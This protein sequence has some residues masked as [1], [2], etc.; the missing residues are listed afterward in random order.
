MFCKN[1][2]IRYSESDLTGRLSMEGLLRLFQDFG[3]EHALCRGLG[4]DKTMESRK[5]WYLLSWKIELLSPPKIGEEVS[6]STWFYELKGPMA[7]KNIIMTNADQDVLAK[8]DTMW[9]YVDVMTQTP[10]LP[11]ADMWPKEDM[12][13]E[14]SFE[15]DSR[16][17]PIIKP[18][19]EN[20]L[21]P[22]PAKDWVIDTNH[23]ANNTKLTLLAMA[24]SGADFG[25]VT[26]RA[27]FINQIPKGAMMYPFM[28]Q[29]KKQI[30]LAFKNEGGTD[31]ANFRFLLQ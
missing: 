29:T 9:V 8:A 20:A 25:C 5:T 22:L 14:L 15:K 6:L 19:G 23:H 26:L 10:T 2:V 17:I 28:E 3:Y 18:S 12:G 31:Y 30:L 13:E 7:K 24:L 4:I 21:R 16:R 1:T 11:Q 27:E